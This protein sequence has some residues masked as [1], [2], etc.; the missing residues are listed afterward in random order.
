MARE[1]LFLFS[2]RLCERSDTLETPHVGRFDMPCMLR[3][4]LMANRAEEHA[5]DCVWDKR[6]IRCEEFAKVG[7]SYLDSRDYV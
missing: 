3:A 6:N 5:S 7:S 2:E 1:C 4:E